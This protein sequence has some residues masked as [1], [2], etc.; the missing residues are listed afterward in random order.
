MIDRTIR[1]FGIGH[2]DFTE[3][4]RV[5][6]TRHDVWDIH[7]NKD[8]WWVITGGTNL[9]SQEQFPNMDLALTFH[10]GLI[11]RIPRTQEQQ[12]NDRLVLP[13]G[14]VFEKTE[15]AGNAVTQAHSLADYQA[16]GVRCREAL[17]ELIGVA[18]DAAIWTQT[19]P[20]R[21]NFRAWSEIICNDLLPGDTNKER[22]GVLKGALDSAWTFSN[23][24]THS[25][26][27]TW[28]D[29]DTAHTLIQHAIEMATSLILR[30]LR[31][32][33]VECPECGSPHLGPE[34][35]ENTAVPGVLWERPRCA[36]CGWAGRPVPIFV[37]GNTQPIITR[38]GEESNEHSIMTVPLRTI[39][40]PGD[41]PIKPLDKTDFGPPQPIIYFAYGSNM[42][43]ARLRKRA[44]SCKPLGVATLPGHSLR[45]HKRST[46][47]S[48]KCNAIPSDS[49][50]GV[51]GV[52]FSFDPADRAK[53]DE[54]EG[55]G[56]GYEHALVTVIN[57]KG[58]R[59]KVLTYL[60]SSNYVDDSLKPYSWYKDL[61]LAGAKEHSLPPKY[62]ADYI[63][64]VEAIDDPDKARDDRQRAKL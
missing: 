49:D 54:A 23:W 52:L 46:D 62:I 1:G 59:R 64:P 37:P 40:K 14:P 55:A 48:G 10:I 43:T 16:V 29:A 63:E 3:P 12:V 51:I 53:L 39:L 34:Q 20:Q 30:G 25:K 24:L 50:N 5:F 32:V 15:E 4:R 2:A 6:R 9:Y 33:P 31:G 41:P 60:A 13:F 11:L 17:L 21:A 22:R 27:A 26:S 42:S 57:E 19:P 36:D 47:R 44:P 7:T 61:V 8:R 38:E 18:Q 58:D 28:I 56:R 45:F 35:G